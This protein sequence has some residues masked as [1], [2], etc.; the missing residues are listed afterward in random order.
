MY[1]ITSA[2]L[3]VNLLWTGCLELYQAPLILD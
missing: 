3:G 1:E 2:V